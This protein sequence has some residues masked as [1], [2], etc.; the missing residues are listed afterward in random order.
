MT[1][2]DTLVAWLPFWELLLVMN[3]I[4]W[5]WL[6]HLGLGRLINNAWERKKE[7]K[8]KNKNIERTNICKKKENTL[9]R[10]QSKC[11]SKEKRLHL[12]VRICIYID[13]WCKQS[14]SSNSTERG[15][16]S[17]FTS[18]QSWKWWYRTF[19]CCTPTQWNST[20]RGSTRYTTMPVVFSVRSCL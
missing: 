3:T 19:S 9:V 12:L 6:N 7:R 18:S 10:S 1:W 20:T 17:T 16:I 4:F 11:K 5:I 2:L 13:Y 15:S 14:G 8:R